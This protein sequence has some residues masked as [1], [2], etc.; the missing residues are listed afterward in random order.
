MLPHVL[1]CMWHNPVARD[2]RERLQHEE[3]LKHP[4]VRNL[5]TRLPDDPVAEEQKIEIQRPSSPPPLRL[6]VA[7]ERTLDIEAQPQEVAGRKPG[8]DDA[9]AVQVR[10]PCRPTGQH[11]RL[12]FEHAADKNDAAA[13]PQTVKPVA[14]VIGSGFDV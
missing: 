7:P 3:P 6:S 8:L 13:G 2:L 14:D 4:R 11:N 12:G 5:E 10:S 1:V 9:S